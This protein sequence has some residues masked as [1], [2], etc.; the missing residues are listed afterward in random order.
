LNYVAAIRTRT[1]LA[2]AATAFLGSDN[3]LLFN[4]GTTPLLAATFVLERFF[5]SSRI[6]SRACRRRIS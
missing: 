5:T 4:Y 3:I 1:R 2:L 6:M